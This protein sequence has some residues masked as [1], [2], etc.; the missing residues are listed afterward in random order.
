M[1]KT[2]RKQSSYYDDTPNRKDKKARQRQI[3]GELNN[4]DYD[5]YDDPFYDD[6]ELNDTIHIQHTKH[7]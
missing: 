2:Y 5:E 4:V 3:L 1:G 6:L 7:K